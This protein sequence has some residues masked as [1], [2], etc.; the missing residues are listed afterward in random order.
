MLITEGRVFYQNIETMEMR[1][2]REDEWIDEL[3]PAHPVLS[4]DSEEFAK[5]MGLDRKEEEP[6]AFSIRGQW[7]S[8][9]L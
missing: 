9:M 8:S 2:D 4:R 1:W 5:A 3:E 6:K 7:N